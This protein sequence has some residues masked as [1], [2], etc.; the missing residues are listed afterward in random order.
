MGILMLTWDPF[1]YQRVL[2]IIQ[3]SLSP[4]TCCSSAFL[5]AAAPVLLLLL[6]VSLTPGFP[7]SDPLAHQTLLSCPLPFHSSL[8]AL[9]HWCFFTSL[10]PLI[11]LLAW[12]SSPPLSTSYFVSFQHLLSKPVLCPLPSSPSVLP[13]ISYHLISLDATWAVQVETNPVNLP[14]SNEISPF[15]HKGKIALKRDKK[16]PFC[17]SSGFSVFWQVFVRTCRS[18]IR[19]KER[20]NCLNLAFMILFFNKF[21]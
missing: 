6:G 20:C 15:W 3:L 16:I 8:L 9:R 21:Q 11:L 5:R 19:G 14:G 17:H 1:P 18:F 2:C 7:A 12:H 4:P 10:F 13:C